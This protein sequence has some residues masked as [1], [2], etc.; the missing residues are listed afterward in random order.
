M[1]RN[2]DQGRLRGRENEGGGAASLQGV[3]VE[4]PCGFCSERERGKTA[5]KNGTRLKDRRKLTAEIDVNRPL[6]G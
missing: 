2:G 4:S 1:K 5:R 3:F 6:I